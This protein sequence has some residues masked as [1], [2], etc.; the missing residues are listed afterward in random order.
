MK[1]SKSELKEIIREVVK[2]EIEKNQKVKL[3]KRLR[4]SIAPKP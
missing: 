2:N 4:K 1:I 3:A